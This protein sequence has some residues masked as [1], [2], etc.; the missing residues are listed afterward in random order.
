[1]QGPPEDSRV[2]I[3]ERHGWSESWSAYNNEHTWTVLDA[4]FA[5]AEEAGRKP[6]QAAINWLLRRPAVTA[7]II[8]AR[9]MEQLEANLGATGWTLTDEQVE[10]LNHASDPGLP[11]P[12]DHIASAQNRR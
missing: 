12:Y 3:A 2:A 9:D 1:M 7:P 5:V 8:G 10:R 6:A 11:Y 4:L